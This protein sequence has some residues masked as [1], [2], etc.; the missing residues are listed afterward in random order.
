LLGALL[1][2]IVDGFLQLNQRKAESNGSV[3][4]LRADESN[5]VNSP[6]SKPGGN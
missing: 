4:G 6:Q 2:A 5:P 3:F 1:E